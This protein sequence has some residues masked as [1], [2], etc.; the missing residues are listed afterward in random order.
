MESLPIHLALHGVLVLF[1]SVVG[2]LLLYRSILHHTNR[3][4]WHLL[5]AG[6]SARGILL[7]ALSAVVDLPELPGWQIEAA[8]WSVVYFAWTSTLAM[9]I[10]AVTG[11]TGFRLSGSTTNRVVFV[12]YASGAV[13]LFPGLLVLAYGLLRAL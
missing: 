8:A 1:L 6:G 9:L 7:I 11:E 2:G 4:D 10:R 12:L 5:H 3:A 13:V